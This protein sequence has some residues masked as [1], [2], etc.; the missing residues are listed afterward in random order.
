MSYLRNKTEMKFS[1]YEFKA[2]V[3]N[4]K[5]NKKT[6]VPFFEDR[7]SLWDCEL[8][9]L[10]QYRSNRVRSLVAPLLSLSG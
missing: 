2:K 3:T 6:S 8:H 5:K 4:L 7:E 10:L 9:T 1:F